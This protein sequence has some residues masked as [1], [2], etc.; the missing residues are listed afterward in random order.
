MKR[1]ARITLLL[2]LA[3]TVAGA[4]AQQPVTLAFS[5]LD[6]GSAWY[7]YGATMAEM[8]RKALPAGSNVDVKPRSGGVGNPRLVAKN[9]TPLGLSFTVTNRWAYE[10]KEA[11]DAKLDNLRALVGGLDTYY[12]VAVVPKKLG[13]A[14]VKDLKDKKLAVKGTTQP[15]GSLGE[16][17]ARQLMRSAGMS[18]ADIK[19]WG[20]S[21]QHAGYN[22]I[23]DAFKDGRADMLIAVVTPKHP[24]V[25][26]IANAVDVKF[27]GLDAETMKALAPLGY[28]PATMPPNTFK[29]QT[30]PVQTVG[31]PT[32]V[33]TNKDLPEPVAYTITRTL[34]ENKDAL[35][36]GHAGLAA[37]D[38]KTAWQPE[39]V[40]I[41]LHPGAE[42][43]FREKGWMK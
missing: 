35:V 18:Y 25:T 16:F 9:E 17:A 34:L 29:G 38:P 27:L 5:T 26:E 2:L 22:V 36:R 15:V 4:W 21:M 31:F 20:G 37:F 1:I 19:A 6:T 33:I 14:G 7:V 11:Y 23:V 30:E 10:G 39:K 24:S 3:V 12:L 8:L 28:V 32:V 40:G 13:L 43:A 41:P 42:R